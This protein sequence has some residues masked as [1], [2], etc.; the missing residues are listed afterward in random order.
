MRITEVEPDYTPTPEMLALGRSDEAFQTG[1]DV[2]AQVRVLAA[3]KERGEAPPVSEEEF[4]KILQ[5]ICRVLGLKHNLHPTQV[6]RILFELEWQDFRKASIAK[7]VAEIEAL[8]QGGD[9]KIARERIKAGR[10]NWGSKLYNKL[11]AGLK[12]LDPKS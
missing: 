7:D 8:I 2:Y 5:A 11:S 9:Y 6:Y 12:T 4:L 1:K 3:Y 10:A